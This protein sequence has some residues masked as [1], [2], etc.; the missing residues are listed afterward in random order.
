VNV[1]D[2]IDDI[3]A[4]AAALKVGEDAAFAAVHDEPFD[5]SEDYPCFV[6]DPD[7]ITDE[8]VTQ[9]EYPTS[10]Y[11]RI[12]EVYILADCSDDTRAARKTVYQAIDERVNLF[13][14]RLKEDYFSQELLLLSRAYPQ[15]KIGGNTVMACRLRFSVLFY[16]E[17]K[18]I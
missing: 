7:S 9:D 13:V 2:W 16:D 18:T 14:E 6:I 4:I 5:D 17:Q 10:P 8:P 11:R 1:Q 15:F 3:L 12:T